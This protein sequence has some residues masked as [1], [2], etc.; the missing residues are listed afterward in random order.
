MIQ[1]FILFIA[2]KFI[3]PDGTRS[4][5]TVHFFLLSTADVEIDANCGGKSI[6]NIELVLVKYKLMLSNITVH[7]RNTHTQTN[8]GTNNKRNRQKDM[9]MHG[10]KEAFK[11]GKKMCEK[12]TTQTHT[13]K[14]R[15]TIKQVEQNRELIQIRIVSVIEVQ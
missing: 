11:L 9:D 12:D 6:F 2:T 5:L 7:C 10:T 15:K 1:C 4:I 8:H 14:F 13:N 3:E